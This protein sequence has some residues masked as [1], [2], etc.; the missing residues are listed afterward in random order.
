MGIRAAILA[1]CLATPA[2]ADPTYHRVVG[3]A[4]DD[5]L[6]IRSA[7][8]ARSEDIGDLPFD[9]TGIE[10]TEFNEDRS[11]ARISAGEKDGWIST[12][13]LQ[14]DTVPTFPQTSVPH[15]LICGG[16]EPFWALGLYGQDARYS[17]PDDTD[18]DFAFDAATVAEGRIGSPALI[19]VAT[20]R[21]EVIEATITGATCSDGM[22]DRTYGW[23][24]T[25]QFIAP[26]K[27]RFLEGCCHLPR[28][29]RQ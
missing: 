28:D 26:G 20:D 17:H 27:R 15:G 5:T 24:V 7:P 2:L 23:S 9:A 21:N 11:W 19:T 10:V 3:V 22:S 6:N 13:F 8:S 25:L 1:L 14:A 12:R 29:E 4:V 16:T 18:I